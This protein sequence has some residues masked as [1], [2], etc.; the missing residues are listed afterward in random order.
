MLSVG[1]VCLPRRIKSPIVATLEG[2]M[3][4]SLS[5]LFIPAYAKKKRSSWCPALKTHSFA[6][7][8]MCLFSVST[9]SYVTV[10]RAP[11]TDYRSLK[12][13]YSRGSKI[14]ETIPTSR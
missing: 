6:R 8:D 3:L 4:P 12:L 9:E 13:V 11:L 10:A 7:L 5:A 1:L 14:E 2:P